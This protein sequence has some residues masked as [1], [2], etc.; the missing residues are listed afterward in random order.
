MRPPG[1]YVCHR[2]LSDVPGE[3][4]GRD[5]FTLICFG[6]TEREKSRSARPEV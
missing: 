5:C 4:A 6:E 3:G 2:P 1:C